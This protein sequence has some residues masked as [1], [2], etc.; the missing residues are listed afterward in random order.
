MANR[1]AMT[2]VA[3]GTRLVVGAL[4]IGGCAVG[5]AAGATASWPQI[6]HSAASTTVSTVPGDT[7]LVCTGPFRALGRESTT[8]E[9][10]DSAGEG[11]VTVGG[12]PAMPESD[13]LSAPGV[14]GAQSVPVFTGAVEGRESAMIAA[15]ESFALAEEDVA[16]LAAAPCAPAGTQSWIVG[17]SVETGANDVLVLSN[18]GDV[19]ATVTLT[20]YGGESSPTSTVIPARTQVALPFS[21]IAADAQD[22][23]VRVVSAGAPVRAVLQSALVRTLDPAGA[24][25]QGSA[26]EA[27]DSLAFAGVH[28]VTPGV[29]GASNAVRLL[30]PDADAEAHVTVRDAAGEVASEFTAPLSAGQPLSFGLND[31]AIGVYS[32][33]VAADT[34]VVGAVW[35]RTGEGAGADFAWMT[36]APTLTG[37]T[38]FAVPS[39]PSPRLH[40]VNPTDQDVTVNLARLGAS[41][42]AITV[43][44]GASQSVAV[45]SSAVYTMSTE[46]GI[47]AS[48]TLSATGQ[49]AGWP[50]ESWAAEQGEVTVYP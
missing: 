17:G 40:L 5:V 16:G 23:V 35:Q 4:V 42:R 10:M 24:D 45:T 34:P 12:E 38:M 20:V 1:R 13:T 49:L 25:L 31:L 29:G 6:E 2:R 32:V 39:G 26:P 7:M 8:A 43:E 22:P 3:T 48:V 47:A 27:S 28:I 9:R 46:T 41:E 14:N 37:D 11:D 33:E 50:I 15:S 36:P 30:S 19:P 44:A 18:P 21:S